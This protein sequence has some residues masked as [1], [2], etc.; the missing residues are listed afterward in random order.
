MSKKNNDNF[1]L[2]T[3]MVELFVELIQMFTEK[4]A[5]LMEARMR[6]LFPAFDSTKDGKI[7]FKMLDDP[8]Q[9]KNPEDLGWSSNQKKNIKLSSLSTHLHTFIIGASG[10]GK[11]NLMNVLME[12][13]LKKNLPVIFI[14]PKG[15]R[16]SINQFKALC[17]K[18]GK[19]VHIFSEHSPGLKKFN[20]LMSMNADQALIMIMRSFDW[21]DKPNE[22]YLNCSR[23]ALKSVLDNLYEKGKKFGFHE[24]YKELELHHQKPET[25]GLRTQLSLLVN[26]TYGQL[27][28]MS[29]NQGVVNMKEAWE[30]GECLYLG[31]STMGYGSLARTIGKMFVSELQTLAHNIGATCE[32]QEEAIKKSIG[33]YI[34]EAGSVLFSDFIDLANKAR[35]SGL[36]LTVAVQSY[37]D[38]EMVGNS[39]TLMKQL[40]ESFSTWFV[41]RQLNPENAEKLAKMFGTF[42]SEKKTKRV[43]S[44]IDTSM[45][46]I[47]EGHE[48]ITHPDILKSIKIGQAIL[49]TLNPKDVH[50]LNIRKAEEVKVIARFADIN[51]H[52]KSLEVKDGN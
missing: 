34:D 5:K 51:K 23:L 47:R 37:S 43:D 27:F 45:G 4:A 1:D 33:V 26:S 7:D 17:K 48:F 13:N 44:G 38:M 30:K 28:N 36:N 25:Q 21:G 9:T 46:T 42:T 22:Y 6:F 49:L 3:P 8:T 52:F 35:S 11:T 32:N 14:D 41:Q 15:T 40:M 39:E 12:N 16:E 29:G 31:I 50:L 19:E 10:W 2:L 20:P 18:Y 24:I